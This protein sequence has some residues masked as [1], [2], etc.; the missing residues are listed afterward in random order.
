MSTVGA[1][2]DRYRGFILTHGDAEHELRQ[3]RS[4]GVLFLR[5][6][7]FF[8]N[9]FYFL[10]ASRA[11]GSLATPIA[12]DAP[13]DM[14]ANADVADYAVARLLELDFA[15]ASAVELYGPE[16][17]TMREIAARIERRVRRPFPPTGVPH[18]VNVEAMVAAGMGRD[19]STLISDTWS[20]FSTHGLLRAGTKQPFVISATRIDAFLDDQFVPALLAD[21]AP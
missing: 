15:G 1:H 13:L 18:A 19:F 4:P 16:V 11:A 2:D 7:Q 5:S 14:A 20:T 6:P 21:G 3:A 17:L 12:A 10:P 9:L 8:E